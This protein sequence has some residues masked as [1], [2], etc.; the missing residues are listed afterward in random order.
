MSEKRVKKRVNGRINIFTHSNKHLGKYLGK[1]R[2]KQ[3]HE[4]YSKC[5]DNHH[6]SIL[7]LGKQMNERL[8]KRFG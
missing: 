1:Y 8:G 6:L 4:H 7:N 3:M 2:G 5:I